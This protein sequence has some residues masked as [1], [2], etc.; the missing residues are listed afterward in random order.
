MTAGCSGRLQLGEAASDV[1]AAHSRV[2][3][4]ASASARLELV[5]AAAAW[6][7]GDCVNLSA[8][9]RETEGRGGEGRPALELG[10]G[11]RALPRPSPAS[12]PGAFPALFWGPYTSPSHPVSPKWDILVALH[13]VVSADLTPRPAQRPLALPTQNLSSNPS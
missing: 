10:G 9:R 5:A 11:F 12:G 1:I 8:A 13:S 6:D 3:T 4:V 2:Q 7:C